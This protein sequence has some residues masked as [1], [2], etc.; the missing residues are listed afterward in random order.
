VVAGA[1]PQRFFQEFCALVVHSARPVE[2]RKV[3]E[4]RD[5]IRVEPQCGA[6]FAFRLGQFAAPQIQQA[7]VEWVSGRS[8]STFSATTSSAVALTRAVCCSAVNAKRSVLVRARAASIRT[9]RR[10]SL[11]QRCRRINK[12]AGGVP[13]KARGAAI[14]TSASGSTIAA[15]IAGFEAG[16][17]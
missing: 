5:E 12:G 17:A 4:R 6:V 2:V 14:L 3:D 13:G 8:A 11:E 1:P 16:D 9:A 15:F 7:E 10:G